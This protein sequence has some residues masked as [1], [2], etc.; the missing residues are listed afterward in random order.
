LWYDTVIGI[1]AQEK[2][3]AKNKKKNG[4]ENDPLTQFSGDPSDGLGVT[5]AAMNLYKAKISY[6]TGTGTANS[7][8][9]AAENLENKQ[10]VLESYYKDRMAQKKSKKR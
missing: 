9:R 7:A 3:M 6:L 2:N 4:R 1:Y 10:R 5:R 8:V